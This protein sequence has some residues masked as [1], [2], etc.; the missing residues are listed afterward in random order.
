MSDRRYN[1]CIVSDFFYPRL[2]GVELHQYQL[3]QAL[4]K[5]GHKVIILTGTY[6]TGKYVRQGIRYLTNGLKV[7]YCPQISLHSQ[8]TL[9]TLYGLWPYFRTIIL[10][11]QIEIIHGH[12]STSALQHECILHAKT[13]G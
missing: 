11:E 8:A 2:G 13:M 9:P 3:A 12:Q 4:I 1:I 6:G 7:Y 5:R 10:R